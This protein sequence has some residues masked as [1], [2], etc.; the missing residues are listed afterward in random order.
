MAGQS[1]KRAVW[2]KSAAVKIA[3]EINKVFSGNGNQSAGEYSK[4]ALG[5]VC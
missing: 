2:K 3:A 1:L 4:L 5:S